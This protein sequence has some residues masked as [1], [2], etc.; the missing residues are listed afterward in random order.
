MLPISD[1]KFVI[2][3]IKH[4]Q[5]EMDFQLENGRVA[6]VAMKIGVFGVIGTRVPDP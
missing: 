4:H 3:S 6:S 1:H 5:I 2:E